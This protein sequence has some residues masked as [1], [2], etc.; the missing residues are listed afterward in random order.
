M[1][2]KKHGNRLINPKEHHLYGIYDFKEREFYKFGISDE[3][4]KNGTSTRITEQVNLFNRVAA[5]VRFA[6]R[7][8]RFPIS[9]RRKARKQEDETILTFQKKHGRLPRGNPKHRFL[10]DPKNDF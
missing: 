2:K 3:E 8:L 10:K 9:K 5:W 1:A 6:R 7:I 4:V